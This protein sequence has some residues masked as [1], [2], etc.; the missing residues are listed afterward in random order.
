MTL[1]QQ[2]IEGA[3]RYADFERSDPFALDRSL[4]HIRAG[5]CGPCEKSDMR[6]AWRTAGGKSTGCNLGPD[7]GSAGHYDARQIG[8]GTWGS[9]SRL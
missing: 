3:K 1:E 5:L 8:V 2:Q 9:V 7:Q 4:C 6:W